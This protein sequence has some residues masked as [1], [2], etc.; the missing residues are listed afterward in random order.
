MARLSRYFL[1]DQPL[2]VIER[3]NNRTAIAFAPD[4]CALY[5]DWFGAAAAEHACAAR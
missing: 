3:G 4:D 1:P 5:R 2:H